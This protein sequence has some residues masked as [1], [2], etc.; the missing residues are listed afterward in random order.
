MDIRNDTE[1]GIRRLDQIKKLPVAELTD[2]EHIKYF[3]TRF[4]CESLAVIYLDKSGEM[5]C[6]GRLRR[7]KPAR[8][9]LDAV[10]RLVERM[11]FKYDEGDKIKSE[12]EYE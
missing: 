10:W 8:L 11:N 6:F 12:K 4:D 7:K 1:S 9:F 5:N 2:E 3:F